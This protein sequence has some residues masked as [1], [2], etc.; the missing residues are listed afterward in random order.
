MKIKPIILVLIFAI[1]AYDSVRGQ[2]LEMDLEECLEYA[3][4][5][6]QTLL[7]AQL[8]IAQQNAFVGETISEGLPQI[9]ANADL[10]KNLVLRTTFLPANF[11]DPNAPSDADPIPVQFGTPYQGDASLGFTQMIFSGSYFVGLKAAK[12]Y[13]ELSSKEHIKS[14]IDVSEAVT[15][16]YYNVLV[17]KELLKQLEANYNRL[18]TLLRETT[19]MYENG[20]AEKIDVNRV[21]VEKNNLETSLQNQKRLYEISFQ[22]LKFQ[23]GMPLK[24]EIEIK[25]TIAELEVDYMKQL[26]EEA[27]YS[28]RIEYS[29]LQTQQ[30]LQEL[31][32]RNFQV[33]YLPSIDLYGNYG[34]VSNTLQAD[35]L[36]SFDE[37]YWFNYQIL[38]LRM[39][40]PI[41]DGLYKSYKVQQTR[42][43]LEQINNNITIMKNN[44]DLEVQNTR[45]SLLNS[46]DNA[47]NQE[48]NM[49]LAEEVYNTTKIKY[50]N[51]VGSNLE[52][53]EADNAY[54]TAQANYYT[55]LYDA[56]VALVDYQKALGI[57]LEEQNEETESIN[58]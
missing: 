35:E 44:I 18:D 25:K 29:Q 41:F 33:Q 1:G 52:L 46:I 4:E 27:S 50:Q 42:I 31:N 57:L 23:M 15:K 5:H 51:G 19:L 58:D 20:F 11:F 36:M 24:Q 3:Y 6:N 49:G 22:L 14:K 48:A 53:I 13:K 7:N 30:R 34:W 2:A 47:R 26:D 38:G 16:A 37:Q 9:N 54:V 8:E 12:T 55:A 43:E 17:T 39:T 40:I 56:F 28:R 10:S 21:T 32:L 45:T